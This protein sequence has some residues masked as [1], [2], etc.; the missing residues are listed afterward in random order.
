MADN[1]PAAEIDIDDA[2]V[3]DLLRRQFP[4]G[5]QRELRRVANGWDNVIYR[6]G[7]H[8]AVRLPRRALAV[9]LVSHEHRWLPQLALTLP[10]PVPAPVHCGRPDEGYPWPWSVCPWF[11]GAVAAVTPPQDL[12]AAARSLGGFVAALHRPAP[13]DA[14]PNPYRGVPLAQRNTALHER[15]ILLG[16]EID[17][18]SVGELWQEA[19]EAPRWDGPALWL[20]GDLHPANLVVHRG[21][22][23]AVI[24]FGDIT[25]GDPAT[26]L[27]VAWMLF[28]PSARRHFR[29]ACGVRDDATWS[30]ARGWALYLAVAMVAHSKD[31]PLMATVGR[32][33]LDAVLSEAGLTV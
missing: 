32:R 6:L 4:A 22:L 16:R 27:A 33:T 17:S 26:D 25:A 12:E 14:P 19:L 1:M 11:E 15:L 18:A 2:L 31:N 9:A 20:H 8:W 7:D 29:A 28:P 5:A 3:R 30:R 10:L 13:L 24:D 21:R 23:R